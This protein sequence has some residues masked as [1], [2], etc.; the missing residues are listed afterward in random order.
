MEWEFAAI[1]RNLEGGCEGFEGWRERIL[2]DGFDRVVVWNG[3]DGMD[4]WMD[5]WWMG[6]CG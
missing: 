3:M 2:A 6:W 1:E 4:G 5:E